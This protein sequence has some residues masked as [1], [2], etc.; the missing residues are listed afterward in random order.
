MTSGISARGSEGQPWAVPSMTREPRPK[1]LMQGSS[2]TKL[3][4]YATLAFG[5]P[6]IMAPSRVHT[7][8]IRSMR[9]I[10]IPFFQSLVQLLHRAQRL[11]RRTLVGQI[12][13]FPT[14]FSTRAAALRERLLE[15]ISEVSASAENPIYEP[16]PQPVNWAGLCRLHG[17]GA[18]ESDDLYNWYAQKEE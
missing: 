9:R 13:S 7:R 4:G 11:C 2:L 3:S 15:R 1:I 17:I 16:D 14:I 10:G 18:H 5:F 6:G 12:V 8:I